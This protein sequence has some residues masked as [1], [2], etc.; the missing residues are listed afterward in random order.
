MHMATKH[1]LTREVLP[2]YLRSTK[3]TKTQILDE[4]CANTGYARKYAIQKLWDFQ[5][6]TPAERE[7]RPRQG[8]K[9][10]YGPECVPPLKAIWE[11]LDFPCGK[12]L[13]PYLPEIVTKLEACG[14][15]RVLPDVRTKLLA[16]SK[17]TI[18]R[19]LATARRVRRRK[20]QC[21]TK[22]G[23]LL[24]REIP[25]R[26]ELWPAETVPGYSE[27]DLVAHCG[28]TTAGD[29]VS[30]L[31][32]TDIA[33][34]WVEH[35]AVL[36]R[37]QSRT[38]ALLEG[39]EARQPFPSLGIDPDNDG[40]FINW[41]LK[42]WCDER[43]IQFTR[44]RPYRKNDNAHVE[45]K[46][47]STVRQLLGYRRLETERQ[48]RL[49]HRLYAGPLRDWQNFFQP[50]LKLR[51]KVWVGARV[52]RRHDTARTPYQRVLE[53]A[54]VPEHKKAALRQHYATLNPVRVKREID[55]I[56]EQLFARP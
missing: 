34:T 10:R 46:N 40:Q 32:K 14:E 19:L 41:H 55:A 39:I 53:S 17:N 51:E 28:G 27:L 9:T 6:R 22:P 37:S 43:G 48:C 36:G 35:G 5:A 8:R 38:I 47:W 56:L 16:M 25:V 45:Q 12:R 11:L 4:L 7:L 20:A 15:F 52:I 24:K 44:S 23:T 21:T 31:T 33:T 49:L 18:D 50:T 42:K 30:T 13:R 29:Y 26:Q 54:H 2:R 1:E 3:T